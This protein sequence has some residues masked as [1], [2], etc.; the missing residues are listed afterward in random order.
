MKRVHDGMR[1]ILKKSTKYTLM[2]L[3]LLA[4]LLGVFIASALLFFPDSEISKR[5]TSALVFDLGSSSAGV[6]SGIQVAFRNE[7]QREVR[8][9][10]GTPIEGYEPSMYLAVFPGLSVTDFEGVEALGGFYTIE[11]GELTFKLDDS[12]LIHSAASGVSN[13][14]MDTLLI[15]VSKRLKV[16]LNDGGTLTQVMEA[17]VRTGQ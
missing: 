8:E 6:E 2:L 11:N 4:L 15:N 5:I 10:L 1:K 16:D 17:L 9:K 3:G 12:G 14:G 13:K 7:L